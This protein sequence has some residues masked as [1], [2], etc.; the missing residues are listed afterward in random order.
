[1]Q[2]RKWK[3]AQKQSSVFRGIASVLVL[4]FLCVLLFDL[5]FS[6]AIRR[7][8]VMQ[9]EILGTKILSETVAEFSVNYPEI[10]SVIYDGNGKIEAIICDASSLNRLLSEIEYTVTSRL[11]KEGNTVFLPL[12]TLLGIDLLSACGPEIPLSVRALGVVR[13][14]YESEISSA[15]INQTHHRIIAHAEMK[16]NTYVPIYAEDIVIH[17]TYC[18]AETVLIGEVPDVTFD[19]MN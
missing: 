10:C 8:L 6:K 15:G 14:T 16:L 12:G 3:K 7:T 4:L 13:F 17:K 11:S 1:M 18:L 19:T 5:L 9:G 2:S